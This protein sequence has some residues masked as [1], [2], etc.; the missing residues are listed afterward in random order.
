MT[1]AAAIGEE[2]LVVQVLDSTTRGDF[3]RIV[4]NNGTP[5]GDSSFEMERG[6][7]AALARA[8]RAYLDKKRRKRAADKDAAKATERRLPEQTGDADE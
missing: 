7:V 5:L 8:C 1:R 4:K 6:L 3:V 2:G